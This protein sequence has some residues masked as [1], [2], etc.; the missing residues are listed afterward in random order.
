MMLD[1]SETRKQQIAEQF[2]ELLDE[3]MSVFDAADLLAE[4]YGMSRP[5]VLAIVK[6]I[7]GSVL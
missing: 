2:Q 4:K 3:R 5:E 1:L 6:E 7:K